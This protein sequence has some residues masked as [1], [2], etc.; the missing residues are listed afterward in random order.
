MVPSEPS[1]GTTPTFEERLFGG[2][3]IWVTLSQLPLALPWPT[4]SPKQLGLLIGA[5]LLASVAVVRRADRIIVALRSTPLL[6]RI[7][8]GGLWAWILWQFL[9]LAASPIHDR[10]EGL[11]GNSIRGGGALTKLALAVLATW[12]ATM[13]PVIVGRALMW[14][15]RATVAVVGVHSGLQ[16]FGIDYAK[17]TLHP[18]YIGSFGNVN[19]ASSFYAF[20]SMVLVALLLA[21]ER[22]TR[23]ERLT[24]FDGVLL[25]W[26]LALCLRTAIGLASRQGLFLLACGMAAMVLSYGYTRWREDT[27]ARRKLLLLLAGAVLVGGTGATQLVRI[28]NGASDR[29]AMWSTG[30]A[31]AR[32]H[33]LRGIGVSQLPYH[34]QVYQTQ[35]DAMSG[36]VFRHVDEIHSGPLQQADELG[37]P[38]LVVYLCFFAAMLPLCFFALAGADRVAKAAA[39]GWL[40]YAIQETFSPFSLVISAWGFAC[41]GVILASYRLQ[42][43]ARAPYPAAAGAGE[44]A[45][46]GRRW[47]VAMTIVGIAAWGLVPR[48]TSEFKYIREWNVGLLNDGS[49]SLI[50]VRLQLR[51]SFNNLERIVA[52]RPY[53]YEM[54]EAI[55]FAAGKNAEP[56][57]AQRIVQ[58]SFLTKP[59]V[60]KQRDFYA[61]IEL[62]RGNLSTALAQYEIATVQFPRSLWLALR[63][64]IAADYLRDPAK[65]A[66]ATAHL[67]SLG[68]MFRVSV[69][70]MQILKKRVHDG[71]KVTAQQLMRP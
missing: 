25:V 18:G 38:G 53:D 23:R 66:A 39:A 70:S 1:Q 36:N 46:V 49:E 40:I 11:W 60:L 62:A 45:M 54:R 63:R 5:T 43:Q 4:V 55:A 33:P 44:T 22:W 51:N 56:S 9:T 3:L 35:Y 7:A 41:A 68:S 34:Y 47:L 13:P 65:T 28:D 17:W 31:I 59:N 10:Y 12:S 48:I 67:D 58:E 37:I 30:V 57:I 29:L 19:Q 69:D 24:W 64:R 6:G 21:P 27:L 14:A 71:M 26:M 61:E 42:G 16:M 50:R 15:F 32:A 52:L 2:I 8:L 20:A